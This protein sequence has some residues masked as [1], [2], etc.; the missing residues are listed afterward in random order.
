MATKNGT[1]VVN[2]VEAVEKAKGEVIA[3]A[4]LRMRT[5][6]V[7]VV[8]DAPYMQARF[9]EKAMNMMKAKQEAG[10]AAKKGGKKDARDFQADFKAA[11]HVSEEGWV[12]VPAAAF[13]AACIDVCRMVGFRMT[14]A[15]MSIFIEA[16]G[17]DKVDG[18]PLVRLDAGEPEMSM[19]AVRNQ[20]GVAD[21]RPRP[22]WRKW[23]VNLRIRFDED[24]FSASDV[25]N[26]LN[27]AGQQVG[28]GE[29][30][31]FSKQSNGLGFGSF[32]IATE[33]VQ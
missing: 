21:L 13:R 4:P 17:L 12:G 26:L 27:R 28:I 29:G 23:A 19:M 10:A 11:Q 33:G 9:S 8:G 5:L 14:Y 1:A 22:M 15:K 3:I 31:P 6:A 7:R 32:T 25:I 2:R 24:Q 30:R 16:D 18:M 20:T